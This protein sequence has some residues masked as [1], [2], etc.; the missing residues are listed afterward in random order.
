MFDGEDNMRV[1]FPRSQ[2]GHTDDGR[3]LTSGAPVCPN[4]SSNDYFETIST[5]QCPDCGLFCDYWG[6]GANAVY[7]A[8]VERRRASV[9]T[10]RSRPEATGGQRY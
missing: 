4:C 9:A 7:D 3:V 6:D 8:M 2:N 5:E 1:T 10:W